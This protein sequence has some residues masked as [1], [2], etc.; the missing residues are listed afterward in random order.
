M[1]IW[2]KCNTIWIS[3]WCSFNWNPRSLFKGYS[4]TTF[5]G[6]PSFRCDLTSGLWNVS[7]FLVVTYLLQLSSCSN[8]CRLALSMTNRQTNVVQTGWWVFQIRIFFGHLR[9]FI[10]SMTLAGWWQPTAWWQLGKSLLTVLGLFDHFWQQQSILGS[11][12]PWQWQCYPS[13]QC[14]Y[15]AAPIWGKLMTRCDIREVREAW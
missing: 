6:I 5:D 13:M 4:R 15:G 9:T 2:F 14:W 1:R 3:S 10:K 7:Y 8:H 12:M 11:A